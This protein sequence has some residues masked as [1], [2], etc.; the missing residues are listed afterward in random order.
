MKLLLT[1]GGLTNQSIVN[2]LKTLVQ[3]PLSQANLAFIPTAANIKESDKS[4]LIQDLVNCQ[5]LNFKQIDIVNILGLEKSN[6][7]TRL[8]SADVI[9]FGGGNTYYL[10]YILQKLHLKAILQKLLKTRVYVGISAGSMVLAPHINLS[11]S[12]KL[13]NESG[14]KLFK[15]K[16]LGFVN[17]QI[18]P[19]LNSP[20]FPN[21]NFNTLKKLSQDIPDTI[22]A[23][24][25]NTAIQV[26]DD[27]VKIVTEGK[28]YKFN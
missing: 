25:D 23:I 6:W 11:H 7:I 5:K 15:D 24:D 28:Y 9:L 12:K 8:E 20:K 14:V 22:Y 21:A 4:W 10:A 19:H 2:S 18:R 26:I 3:K 1:S 13:Y 17:F 16:G 27:K